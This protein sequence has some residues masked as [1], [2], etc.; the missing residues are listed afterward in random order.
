MR[1]PNENWVFYCIIPL[2]REGTG[3]TMVAAFDY[4]RQSSD[5]L[6]RLPYR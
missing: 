6:E 1:T 5:L 3:K 4:A 2:T